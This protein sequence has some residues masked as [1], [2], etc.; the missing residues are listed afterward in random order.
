MS[1]QKKKYGIAFSSKNLFHDEEGDYIIYDKVA[2]EVIPNFDDHYIDD[3]DDSGYIVPHGDF[4]QK[5]FL[6]Q[7]IRFSVNRNHLTKNIN[8]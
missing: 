4:G 3:D 8:Y 6:T 5:L 1:T 7:C 2:R